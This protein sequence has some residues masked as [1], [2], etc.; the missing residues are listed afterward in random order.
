MDPSSSSTALVDTECFR[1]YSKGLVSEERIRD[2]KVTVAGA[3]V[4]ICDPRDSLILE[5]RKNLEAFVDGQVVTNEVAELEALIEGLNKA[6]GLNLK[7]LTFFCDDYV[8][9]R[10]VS[11]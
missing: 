3:G 10:Y 6:L 2:M 5:V 9:Y 1:L 11:Q 8:L 7:R 4:A